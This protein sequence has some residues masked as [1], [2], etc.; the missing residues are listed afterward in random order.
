V[1]LLVVPSSD[2]F[3]ATVLTAVQLESVE[4]VA[5][6]SAVLTPAEQARRLGH[7]W[8]QMPNRPRR[9]LRYRVIAP[10]G[11][12]N[13]FYLGAHT[14]QLAEDDVDLI[15]RLWLD[16]TQASGKEHAHHRDVVHLALRH[17]ADDL[18]GPAHDILVATFAARPSRPT[19]PS[20][21]PRHDDGAHSEA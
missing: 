21:G 5:G 9:Q 4:I 6:R 7:A 12:T 16:L 19:R 1:A 20:Q 11:R 18:T 2:V 15:H 3:Q 8:E 17:L 14:P 13:V 10:D